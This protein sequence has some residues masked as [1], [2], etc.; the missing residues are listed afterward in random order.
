MTLYVRRELNRGN[1]HV[2]SDKS[3]NGLLR[4][5]VQ[6]I[7]SARNVCVCAWFA[8]VTLTL[9]AWFGQLFSSLQTG[10][11]QS[12]MKFDAMW[13]MYL[14]M[15]FHFLCGHAKL[16]CIFRQ[17]ACMFFFFNAVSPNVCV[18]VF[19]FECTRGTVI[20]SVGWHAFFDFAVSG[21]N[22]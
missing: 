14:S 6:Q 20:F 9:H 18:L 13:T 12:A 7:P 17:C 1:Q 16:I 19:P 21:D 8:H 5:S 4:T 2:T 11:P 10:S 22:R 15:Q 3:L